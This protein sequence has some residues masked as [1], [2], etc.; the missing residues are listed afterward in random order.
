ME[1]EHLGFALMICVQRRYISLLVHH[2]KTVLIAGPHVRVLRRESDRALIV[3]E[4]GVKGRETLTDYAAPR[5]NMM[6]GRVLNMLRSSRGN[7]RASLRLPCRRLAIVTSVVE[8]RSICVSDARRV[9]RRIMLA[10]VVHLGLQALV[11]LQR[12]V[13]LV[14]RH[15]VLHL[16]A[17]SRLLLFARGHVGKV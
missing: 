3:L 10:L 1:Q 9:N 8:A 5:L 11:R 17:A 2:M 13:T 16:A 14:R 15:T 4:E 12:S 7:Y 6:P